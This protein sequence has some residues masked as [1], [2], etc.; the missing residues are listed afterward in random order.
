MKPKV[1]P[2][3]LSYENLQSLHS[4]PTAQSTN[5][6]LHQCADLIHCE[7]TGES[8]STYLGFLA[9][10]FISIY[11]I[12]RYLVHISKYWKQREVTILKKL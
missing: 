7:V 2:R 1:L 8:F 12:E 4:L 9:P 11:K 10:W 5:Y 3:T 6:F